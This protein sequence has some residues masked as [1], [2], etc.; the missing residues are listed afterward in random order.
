MVQ[1]VQ[2]DPVAHVVPANLSDSDDHWESAKL[3]ILAK[4][5]RRW[6]LPCLISVL[7][8]LSVASV[9]WVPLVGAH[10]SDHAT[11]R[12]IRNQQANWVFEL[13]APLSSLDVAM[14]SYKQQ[15]GSSVENVVSKSK[16]HKELLVDYVKQTFT[17]TVIGESDLNDEINDNVLKPRLGK[18]Q[19]K[20]GDHISVFRFEILNMPNRVGQLTFVLPF[21]QETPGQQ[22]LLQLIDSSKSFRSVLDAS[23]LYSLVETDFF[24]AAE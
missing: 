12:V 10:G 16:Q 4:L 20:L 21:M 7:A 13:Q 18:G 15:R 3:L 2:V 1:A 14:K 5:N 8:V 22:N 24:A 19:M 9:L 11:L 17:V 6:A 23:N